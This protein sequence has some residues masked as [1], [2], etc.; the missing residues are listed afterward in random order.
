MTDL[1]VVGGGPAGLAAAIAARAHGLSVTVADAGSPPIDKACGEGL[2]PDSL[3]ALAELGVHVSGGHGFPFRGIRFLGSGVAVDASFP[4][5][6]AVGVRRLTLHRLLID[7]ARETGVRMLWRSPVGDI[8]GIAARWI[9]GA[10]GQHSRVRRAA[11]LDAASRHSERFG[12]RRHYR[13][14]PWTD[15]VEIYWG[16]GCQIYVTPVAPDEVGVALISR[17]PRLRLDEAIARFP[18]LSRQLGN[19]APVTA[20]KGAVSATRRLR[21]VTRNRFALIG[22]ASGSVDAI[23]G[24]GL[25]LAFQQ[26]VILAE[27]LA[28]QRLDRYESAHT[29][30]MRRPRMMSSLML[31]LDRFPALRHRAL[32]AFSVRPGIFASM[33]AM[34]VGALSPL[35]FVTDAMMPLGLGIL[36]R[37]SDSAV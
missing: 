34:H 24:E 35:A 12:F 37:A 19:H 4:H 15:C 13:V 32:P 28:S 23:T 7:R 26:A 25:C 3:A 18:D 22:D 20:E 9:V 10:D 6:S 31:M 1:F 5:G 33:L 17:N 16:D 30:M 11:G 8:D 29:Q 14:A 21:R 27:A 36:R 2:M